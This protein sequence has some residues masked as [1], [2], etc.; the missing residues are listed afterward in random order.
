MFGSFEVSYDVFAVSRIDF[1]AEDPKQFTVTFGM[2]WPN[3]TSRSWPE[4]DLEA[5]SVTDFESMQG[6]LKQRGT[7]QCF[8]GAVS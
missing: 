7:V 8:V 6:A 4:G 2:A 5:D 1:H 3:L